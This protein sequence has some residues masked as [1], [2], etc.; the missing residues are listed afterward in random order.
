[1]LPAPAPEHGCNQVEYR[2]FWDS[3]YT[4]SL[5]SM[6]NTWSMLAGLHRT[7]HVLLD[8]GRKPVK[9]LCVWLV[10]LDLEWLIYAFAD[11]GQA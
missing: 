5:A 4:C 9:L 6:L 8:I 10:Y 2:V 11:S 7:F 3:L 1:M